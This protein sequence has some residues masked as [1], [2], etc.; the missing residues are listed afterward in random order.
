MFG[1]TRAVAERAMAEEPSNVPIPPLIAVPLDAIRDP[2]DR[3]TRA[4]ILSGALALAIALLLGMRL[5]RDLTR[6]VKA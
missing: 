4:L 2:F 3:I 1:L 5:S 6:P